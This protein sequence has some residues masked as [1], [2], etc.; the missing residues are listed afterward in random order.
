LFALTPG[1]FSGSS[2]RCLKPWRNCRQ[3]SNLYD[4]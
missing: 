3:L 4:C 2:L 1:S